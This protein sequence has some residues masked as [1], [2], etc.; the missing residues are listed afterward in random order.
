MIYLQFKIA[1]Q[2]FRLCGK[3]LTDAV[4]SMP[5]FKT[6]LTSEEEKPQFEIVFTEDGIEPEII[7]RQYDF[8]ADGVKSVFSAIATGYHLSMNREDGSKLVLWS[9]QKERKVY[10]KGSLAP[11]LLRFALW[12]AYGIMSVCNGRIPIHGSCIV[13]D[14]RAYLFLGESGTGKSTHTRLWREYIDGSTL[15]ND[16]SPIIYA[17]GDA[18]YVYG[19]PWSGKTPCYR[20]ERYPL[21][22]CV[23]LSQAPYN[24]IT[25]LSLL[26]SYAA[27]HPSCPPE[28]AYDETLYGGISDTLDTLLSSV[29]IFYLECLPDEDAANLS[30]KTLSGNK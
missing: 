20:Q 1:E 21:C 17:E 8:E 4:I 27:M 22:G 23:R 18:V 11:Q 5:G 29:S 6:F 19:S 3:A 2:C 12:I 7:A 26:K 25:R 15:L 28:F 16:D 24:R 13:N 9:V 10:L 30:F 14:G